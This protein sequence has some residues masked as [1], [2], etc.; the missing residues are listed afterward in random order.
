MSYDSYKEGVEARLNAIPGYKA[1][2][3]IAKDLMPTVRQGADEISKILP[4]FP[5]SVQSQPEMGTFFEPTP[6]EVFAESHDIDP[7]AS[8]QRD[9]HIPQKEQGM[10]R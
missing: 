6:Q 10:E 2:E 7:L 4:A 8:Y 3:S 9:L 1:L 5:D